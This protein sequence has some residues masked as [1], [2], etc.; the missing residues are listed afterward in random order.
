MLVI[1]PIAVFFAGAS[2]PHAVSIN[3]GM[4]L[5][6]A[7][8][9][10]QSASAVETSLSEATPRPHAIIGMPEHSKYCAFPSSKAVIE[11][12]SYNHS[13]LAGLYLEGKSIEKLEIRNR[14]QDFVPSNQ[15]TAHELAEQLRNR[16]HPGGN[17]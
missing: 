13:R 12:T 2:R 7:Y 1:I 4:P 3:V 17:F 5:E 16:P 6:D 14:G 8:E 15:L 11:T 10:L 9:L